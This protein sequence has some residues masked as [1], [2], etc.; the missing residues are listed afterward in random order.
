MRKTIYAFEE[1]E[2]KG[3]EKEIKGKNL[4]KGKGALWCDFG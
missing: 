2:S 4:R 3:K 1:K